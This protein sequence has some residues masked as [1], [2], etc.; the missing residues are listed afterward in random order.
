MLGG[1]GCAA[2]LV[3][4]THAG[5]V[6]LLTSP[7]R[8]MPTYK[9]LVRLGPVDKVRQPY[10]CSSQGKECGEGFSGFVVSG[11]NATELLEA[12]EHPLDTVPVLVSLEVAGRG[13]LSVGLWRNDRPDAVDQ[14]FFTHEVTVIAFVGEKQPR[15]ADRYRQQVRNGVVVRS[16]S[17]F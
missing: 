2:S 10:L 5:T 4:S 13:I 8:G 16:L 3:I 14:E 12:V 7:I 1:W 6:Y 11:R 15:L 9:K 17:A